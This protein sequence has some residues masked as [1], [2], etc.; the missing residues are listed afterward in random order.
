MSSYP[1]LLEYGYQIKEELGRNRE[2]GRITWK[3]I[4]IESQEIVVIK[5]FCFAQE[6][7]SWSGYKAHYKEIQVLQRLNHPAIPQYLE[8]W[9]TDDGFF[10]VQKYI[11][12]ANCAL[13]R[14]LNLNKVRQI[15]AQ[16]LD[17]LIYLQQQE[18]AI[19]HGDIKPENILLDEELNTYLIDFGFAHPHDRQLSGSSIFKGTPGFIPPE[20]ILQP[21]LASDLYSLGVT[22]IYLLTNKTLTEITAAASPDEP[23][24]L[25]LSI[26][27]PDIERSFWEWL[28]KMTHAK[29]SQRFP[30]AWLAK[31]ALV[32]LDAP[33]AEATPE[34]SL[35][36]PAKSKIVLGTLGIATLS[37][38]AVESVNFALKGI[39]FSLINLAIAILAA[40]AIGVTQLG[41]AAIAALEPQTR[42]Q[43]GI[44]A[45]VIPTLLVFF[46]ALIWGFPEAVLIAAA[47]S[48]AE[49]LVISYYWWQIFNW[50]GSNLVRLVSWMVTVSTAVILGL[51]LI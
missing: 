36:Y 4:K 28:K 21:T 44:L 27:L 17:I 14:G 49:T 29:L 22:L 19:L 51:Q 45:T 2:G 13:Q 50:R 38:I 24:Q 10:L 16:L 26:L 32:S 6:N 43:G 41:A 7:S 15:A 9:S 46:S 3:A 42:L 37:I 5:Q 48:I 31:Q 20:Q 40:A 23:Y 11:E 34:K 1:D 47:V 33:L 39:E 18:P 35:N 30:N 25:D 12:A 8:S